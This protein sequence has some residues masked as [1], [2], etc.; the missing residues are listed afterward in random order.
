MITSGNV[1]VDYSEPTFDSLWD[2][3][4]TYIAVDNR[5]YDLIN[6]NFIIEDAADKS[7][8][9]NNE[10]NKCAV[11]ISSSK[12]MNS[13]RETLTNYNKSFV[14]YAADKV[15]C[16]YDYEWSIGS[17]DEDEV[18]AGKKLLSWMLGN[19]YQ[20]MLMISH[21]SDGQIPINK[22]CFKTKALQKNYTTIEKIY[23]KYIFEN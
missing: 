5:Y 17:S 15:S 14:Y 13:I 12:A 18:K 19:N 3:D 23:K 9:L 22:D 20:N 8:F 10:E 7:E 6:R 4:T 21:A 1:S 11:L 16:K 2:F